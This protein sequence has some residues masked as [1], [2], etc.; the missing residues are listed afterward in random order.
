M[1]TCLGRASPSQRDVATGLPG[2][3]IRNGCNKRTE[4]RGKLLHDTIDTK[5]TRVYIHY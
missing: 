1:P 4:I 3:L 5:H 2:W